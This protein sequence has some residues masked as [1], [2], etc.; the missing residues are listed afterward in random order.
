MQEMR[1]VE[2][3][4][5]PSLKD[6]GSYLRYCRHFWRDAVLIAV[7]FASMWVM[8]LLNRP[9][10]TV[11]D[12][13]IPFDQVIPL[14]P[15]TIVIYMSWAPLII[16]LAVVYF[17]YDRHLMRRYLITLGIGQ[18]M[19]NVTFPFFQ[20]MIPRPYEEVF[21]GTDIFS[22]ML[23]IV[24]RVDNH[25]CG[26]PSIHVINCVITMVM[27]WFFREA[28]LWVKLLVTIYFGFIAIS[29]VTTKQHVVLDIPG[30]IVYGL[31][32]IPLSIPVIRL[33]EKK[34]LTESTL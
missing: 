1:R 11:R 28:K 8:E 19:A 7:F 5:T 18:L 12:L 33:Y 23:A 25:Y 6:K 26:F 4:S 14:M 20:T 13:S 10:G 21:A 29:T 32:A 16:A 30:G 34:V 24:Y 2:K 22:K 15:W 27:I 9:F 17:L 31:L 3:P